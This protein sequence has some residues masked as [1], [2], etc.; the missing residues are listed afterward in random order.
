MFT[1][2][3]ALGTFVAN[4]DTELKIKFVEAM[5]FTNEKSYTFAYSN[6]VENFD[7]DRFKI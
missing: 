5:I 3:E 1:K 2:L 4:D 6:T 7:N